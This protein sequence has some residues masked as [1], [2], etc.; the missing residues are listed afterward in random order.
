MGS[1]QDE[2]RHY[3]LSDIDKMAPPMMVKALIAYELLP[4]TDL[5]KL[6][7][8][9]KEGV[10]NAITYFP[11]MA[12]NLEIDD[13]DKP[14]I[15]TLPGQRLEP[16]VHYFSSTEHKSFATLSK[17]SFHPDDLD[18]TKLLPENPPDQQP[19]CALQLNIIDGGMILAFAFHHKVGD[20]SSLDAFLSLVCR[21]T[22]AHHHSLD[23][24]VY[25]P[26]MNKDAFT[27]DDDPGVSQ[28][29]LVKEF[30]RFYVTD[31]QSLLT[32]YAANAAVPFEMGIYQITESAIQQIKEQCKDILDG[33]DF[34]S[35][36]DCISALV[37]TSVTR[38]RLACHPEKSSKQSILLHPVDLRS[39]D[40]HNVTS[41]EY[42]GNGV[43]PAQAGPIDIQFLVADKGVATAA[44][45]IR[46]SINE[47]ILD[48]K[49]MKTLATLVRSLSL[50][51]RLGYH[52][53][54]NDM[55]IFMNSWY[56]GRAEN[57]DIGTGS[58][59]AFR[60]H[61]LIT[62]AC[63]L[64]LPNFSRSSTRVYE[65]F[66]QLQKDEFQLLQRDSE[67]SRYFKRIV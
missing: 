36:Y 54:F 48:P 43:Q 2:R 65:L 51:Q 19:L 44:S 42:F 61:R 32:A 40:P 57:Y 41:Q 8:S 46:K 1:I 66:I 30:S 33:V 22:K 20:W 63:C 37:W 31:L 15:V 6:T 9:L 38:A 55:D 4:D 58:P 11:F 62:G 64:I 34:V 49:S 23:M 25:Q 67:F 27:G 14:Y 28:Q 50:T 24:P 3:K 39:R 52:F 10:R 60:T 47:M 59:C 45:R 18:P 13:T 17:E 5:D 12:G 16:T 53:D 26:D 7:A 35:S 21:G 56:S 29:D